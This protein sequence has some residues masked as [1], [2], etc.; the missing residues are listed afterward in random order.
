MKRNAS[1][2]G[3]LVSREYYAHSTKP[4][5]SGSQLSSRFRSVGRRDHIAGDGQS[6]LASAAASASHLSHLWLLSP[7]PWGREYH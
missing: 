6:V 3:T 7:V 1:L 4:S 2:L 5:S